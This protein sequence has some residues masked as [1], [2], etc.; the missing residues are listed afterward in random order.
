[1][2][3]F[4]EGI[5]ETLGRHIP[6]AGAAVII[7]I[8]GWLL[9][10]VVRS[11]A[12]RLL[13][14]VALNTR[15]K[16][17]KNKDF[18]VEAVVASGLFYLILLVTLVGVANVLDLTLLSE[19]LQE[20]VVPFFA[21]V[22]KLVGASILGV[23]AWVLAVL[24]RG[25][26]SRVLA[27]SSLDE[28]FPTDE[29]ARPV[30]KNLGRVVQWIVV[31]LFLPAILS[32]LELRGLLNP[33]EEMVTS[34]LGAVP[35]IAG[36]LVVGLV[37]W[38]VAGLLRD[39]VTGL[40]SSSGADKLGER[41]GFKETTKLS[42][43][44]GLVVQI[45]VFVPALIA[46]LDTLAINS[47]SAPATNLLDA[48]VGSLPNLLAAA[49]IIAVAIIV[50]RFVTSL[51]SELLQRVGFDGLPERLGF[52]EAVGEERRLS[53]I[54]GRVL[55]FFII[56]F[57]LVE[58]AG[59]LELAQVEALLA[60]FIGFGAQVLLGVAIL[61]IG[62]W[63][64][65]TAHGAVKKM[66]GDNAGVLAGIARVTILGLVL[67]MGLRS[68]GIADDIVNLA[69]GLTLGSVAVAFAIAFGF[70]GREPAGRQL[71]AWFKRLRKEG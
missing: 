60:M 41:I 56:F 63:L 11:G 44:V 49:A 42:G 58:A 23:T 67:A 3:E 65:N 8:V 27:A 43:L 39:I 37:G 57:A 32:A 20:L 48:L 61:V 7:A 62:F 13:K 12:K 10:G 69:F 33:V 19:P 1:M 28:R 35:N 45:A 70:G 64:A 50:G 22:P 21:F 29:T 51:V 31:L 26:I 71:E 38:F 17:G 59:Q 25:L 6:L 30:S 46:A 9:A 5:M 40:L 55:Y 66:G 14:R 54:A 24:A 2:T 68:M 18:D 4:F 34:I 47:I 53:V 36:A 16:L 15:V 52:A